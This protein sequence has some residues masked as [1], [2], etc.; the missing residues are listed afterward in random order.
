[1]TYVFAHTVPLAKV[2][3]ALFVERVLTLGN[4]VRF[5]GV[6]LVQPRVI[7]ETLE[8]VNVLDQVDF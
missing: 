6:A 1:M 8:P 2:E 4:V 3:L 7:V 5:T